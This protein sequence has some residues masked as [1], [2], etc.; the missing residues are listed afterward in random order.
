MM[1]TTTTPRDAELNATIL[2]GD[3]L[4]ALER[5]YDDDCE[6]QE[7]MEQPCRGKDANRIREEAFLASVAEFHGARLLASAVGE[8]VSFSEWEFDTTYHDGGRR[9]TTQATIRRWHH[10]RVIHER[11]HHA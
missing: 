10:G 3:L 6:M 4:G 8:G 2:A 9:K 7:N 11:F 5:F 1:T